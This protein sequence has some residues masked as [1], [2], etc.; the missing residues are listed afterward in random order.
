MSSRWS[1]AIW[2]VPLRIR[3]GRPIGCVRPIE[4]VLLGAGLYLDTS[5]L[6][7]VLLAEPGAKALHLDAALALRDAGTVVRVMTYD[8]QLQEAYRHH[9]VAVEARAAS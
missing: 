1:I 7:R 2:R 4:I 5:A 8:R 3:R 9:A 6:G